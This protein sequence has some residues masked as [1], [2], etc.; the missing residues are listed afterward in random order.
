MSNSPWDN[1]NMIISTTL[2]N[3]NVLIFKFLILEMRNI[4]YFFYKGYFVVTESGNQSI[5]M[6]GLMDQD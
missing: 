6:L 2:I 1:Y 4:F 3:N 5:D